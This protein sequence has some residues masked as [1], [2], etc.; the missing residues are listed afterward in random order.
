MTIVR[1]RA[2]ILRADR[3]SADRWYVTNGATAVGPVA[4]ELVERG[5]EAGKIPVDSYIRHE[6]WKIWR[7]LSEL[8]VQTEVKPIDPLGTPLPT[9]MPSHD[10][11]FDPRETVMQPR[12]APPTPPASST[13]VLLPAPDSLPYVPAQQ[14]LVAASSETD[15]DHLAEPVSTTIPPILSLRDAIEVDPADVLE[16]EPSTPARR[17]QPS[18]P[19]ARISVEDITLPPR[20]PKP[21]EKVTG[22]PLNSA[23]QL[24]DALLLLSGVI[25][26]EVG[27]EGVMVHRVDDDGAVAV[28]AH[29]PRMFDVIGLRTRLLD[30]AIVAAA[31]GM[32][33]VAEPTPGPAGEAIL[34]R[35]GKL[36]VGGAGA[37]MI[38]IRPNGRLFGTLEMGQAGAFT[39]AAIAK[40]EG[41]VRV[42]TAKIEE[43]GWKVD[44]ASAS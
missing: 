43:A 32:L 17:T 34:S 21:A 5:I 10:G 36:G 28:V 12:M 44:G 3:A 8:C 40:A 42:V 16:D 30:P 6:A 37:V 1:L 7:P 11:R 26:R 14:A 38:P 41:F 13:P 2:D 39:G 27:C 24:K 33:V 25:F 31:A 29:G 23:D 20:E 15:V 35:L 4:L 19:R 18:A 9:A 22:D